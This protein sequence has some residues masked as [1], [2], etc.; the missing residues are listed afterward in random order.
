MD[1]RHSLYK[2]LDQLSVDPDTADA[3]DIDSSASS[4]VTPQSIETKLREELGA[5]HVEIADLSG[6]FDA[7]F[8]R[9]CVVF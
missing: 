8:P 7:F 2:T 9:P 3:M 5:V 4:G 6:M 1:P